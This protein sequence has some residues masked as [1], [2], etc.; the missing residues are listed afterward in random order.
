MV[1][2]YPSKPIYKSTNATRCPF[3]RSASVIKVPEERETFRS[4]LRPPA[5]T[6]IFIILRS[7]FAVKNLHIRIHI[8]V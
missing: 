7:L 1:P 3:L 6:T 5:N 2:S 8:A 4:S